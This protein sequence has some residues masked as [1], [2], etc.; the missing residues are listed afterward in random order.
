MRWRY[1]KESEDGFSAKEILNEDT[2][3]ENELDAGK[4]FQ[5]KIE[6]NSKLIEWSDGTF[7]LAI[8]DEIFEIRNEEIGTSDV[9]IKYDDLAIAKS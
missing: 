6:S 3:I 2:I 1:A 7:G 4:L 8:G 9:F 5:Q